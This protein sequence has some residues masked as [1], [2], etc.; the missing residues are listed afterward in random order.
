V[1][2]NLGNA[3]FGPESTYPTGPDG[4]WITPADLDRDGDVDLAIA[5][6][7]FESTVS[8][9]RN[10][11]LGVF[12]SAAELYAAGANPLSIASGDIDGD[13]DI[14]LVT[15]GELSSSIPGNITVYW[16]RLHRKPRIIDG[17]QD[18]FVIDPGN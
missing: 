7:S 11:G 1:F 14:D 8:L 6:E 13:R 3:T 17:V 18:P 12:G 16:N 2:L 9:L 10:D 5:T 4:T 15:G